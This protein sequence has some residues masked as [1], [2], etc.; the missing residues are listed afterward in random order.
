[1]MRPPPHCDVIII[2]DAISA[3]S[4]CTSLAVVD[5]KQ[6]EADAAAEELVSAACGQFLSRCRSFKALLVTFSPRFLLILLFA[7]PI[8]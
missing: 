8:L 6:S 2:A 3:N 5:L 7:S 4:G 1:M